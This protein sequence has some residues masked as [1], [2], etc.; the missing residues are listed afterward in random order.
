M[1]PPLGCVTRVTVARWP[2]HAGNRPRDPG[3]Y[4]SMGAME[5]LSPDELEAGFAHVRAAP[6]D[7]GTLR[8]I[9]ARPAP[10]ERAVLPEA[11]LS[12]DLGLVTD[13]WLARGSR[14]TADGAADPD[15]QITVMN[16]RVAELVAGGI[17]RAPL[18]G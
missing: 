14:H 2:H 8:L 10:A 3:R 6:A 18:A 13:N 9:V 11:A 5:H 15:R 16:A 12:T 17:E 4:G 1:G 7:G